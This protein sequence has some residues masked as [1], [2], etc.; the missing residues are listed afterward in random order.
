M[1]LSAAGDWDSWTD[2]SPKVAGSFQVN[3]HPSSSRDTFR[4]R[5]GFP[6]TGTLTFEQ[7]SKSTEIGSHMEI[8]S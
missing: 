7:V 8:K 1:V 3:L 5:S 2:W 6:K 4:G